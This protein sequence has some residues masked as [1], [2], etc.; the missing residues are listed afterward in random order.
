MSPTMNATYK[1]V[2]IFWTSE[3]P[4]SVFWCG[5]SDH[6]TSSKRQWL[7]FLV[8]D[9]VGNVF[10]FGGLYGSRLYYATV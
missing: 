9:V 4:S 10:N 1:S 8:R 7:V 5:V 3:S 2:L 6:H